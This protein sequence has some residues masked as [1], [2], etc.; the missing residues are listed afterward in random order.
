MNIKKL[1]WVANVDITEHGRYNIHIITLY[2]GFMS[3]VYDGP[4]S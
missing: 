3:S 2:R 4:V 1:K